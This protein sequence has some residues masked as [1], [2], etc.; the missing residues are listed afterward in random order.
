MGCKIMLYIMELQEYRNFLKSFGVVCIW[1]QGAILHETVSVT[2]TKTGEI[3]IHCQ[4]ANIYKALKKSF[5]LHPGGMSG[6]LLIGEVN[7][8]LNEP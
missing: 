3:I 4:D 2:I 6:T 1:G 7:K 8:K 5:P